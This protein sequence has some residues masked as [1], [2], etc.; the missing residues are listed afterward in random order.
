MVAKS[1]AD[2]YTLLVH[3]NAHAYCAA[4]VPNLPYDSLTELRGVRTDA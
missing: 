2:G 1:R 3:T 4:V